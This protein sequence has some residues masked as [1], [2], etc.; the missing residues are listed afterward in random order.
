MFGNSLE[1]SDSCPVETSKTTPGGQDGASTI[2][3]RTGSE[4]EIAGGG[5]GSSEGGG[6]GSGAT[7]GETGASDEL[8]DIDQSSVAL[9]G[10]KAPYFLSDPVTSCPKNTKHNDAG[11]MIDYTSGSLAGFSVVNTP[12]DVLKYSQYLQANHISMDS[13]TCMTNG[14]CNSSYYYDDGGNCE[15]FA[16]TFAGNLNGNACVSND[17][18]ASHMGRTD[19]QMFSESLWVENNKASGSGNFYDVPRRVEKLYFDPRLD[20]DSSGKSAAV[21]S[22]RN[23]TASSRCEISKMILA[24]LVDYGR[25]IV[26]RIRDGSGHWAVAVGVKTATKEAYTSKSGGCGS[27]VPSLDGRELVILNT[28]GKVHTSPEYYSVLN[29]N[30]GTYRVMTSCGKSY[31]D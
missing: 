8:D 12:M 3:G 1:A 31:C 14:S 28:D 7:G 23:S 26:V 30:N 17:A 15:K 9:G 27:G 22:S 6:G 24:E 2:P 29:N 5:G 4:G 19:T 20:F 13:K 16:P 25:P 11:T 10:E 18:F 21:F